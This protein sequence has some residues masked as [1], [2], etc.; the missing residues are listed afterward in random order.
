MDDPLSVSKSGKVRSDPKRLLSS[1]HVTLPGSRW[2]G[3]RRPNRN[4]FS[5]SFP[6]SKE[7]MLSEGKNGEQKSK[8]EYLLTVLYKPS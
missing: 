4:I 7:T 1:S 3:R 2:A 8:S 5:I 6:F